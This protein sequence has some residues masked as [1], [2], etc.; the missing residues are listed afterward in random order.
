MNLKIII[1]WNYKTCSQ[2][3]KEH[4]DKEQWSEKNTLLIKGDRWEV[5]HLPFLRGKKNAPQQK[6][7]KSIG[8]HWSKSRAKIKAVFKNFAAC[9]R[10]GRTQPNIQYKAKSLRQTKYLTATNS[11]TGN[12]IKMQFNSY[13]RPGLQ[14]PTSNT[15]TPENGQ[16]MSHEGKY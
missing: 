1:I 12:T 4:K 15:K 13:Q 14:S 9:S 5:D 6:P 7:T 16:V 3:N 2:T 10:M 8:S 11:H